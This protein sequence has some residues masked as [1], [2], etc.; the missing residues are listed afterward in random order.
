[1]IVVFTQKGLRLLYETDWAYK[2][3]KLQPEIVQEY[4]EVIEILEATESL[5]QI[6]KMKSLNCEN[7]EGDKKGIN[8]NCPLEPNCLITSMCSNG[9]H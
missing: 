4:K 2:Y 5:L 7:L 8:P 1:M 6:R 9:H 3:H